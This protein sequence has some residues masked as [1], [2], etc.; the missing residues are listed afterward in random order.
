M[1]SI[2]VPIEQF[3]K[4]FYDR[5]ICSKGFSDLD[6]DKLAEIAKKL[7]KK[8]ENLFNKT[9]N[10]YEIIPKLDMYR[11]V[12]HYLTN[13]IIHFEFKSFDE[14]IAFLI[15]AVDPN[16]DMFKEY[17]KLDLVSKGDI[18]NARDAKE[19]ISLQQKRNQTLLEYEN[20]VREKLG[21]FDVKLLKYEELFFKRFFCDK[22]LITEVKNNNQDYLMLKARLL[23]NFDTVSDERFEELI[24]VA[25][26]WLSLVSDKKNAKA[27]GY[28]VINQKKLLGLKSVAEQLTLYILLVDSELDMLRIF[29]EES[30]M[31]IIE[32]RIIEQF[33][34]FDKELLILEKKYHERFC[35]DKELSIWSKTKKD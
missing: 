3:K 8:Q 16:L 7:Y 14:K 35:R 2:Y 34:F 19:K 6:D 11:N 10:G 22:E 1:A 24:D 13:P 28:S 18:E 4:K 29:E 9:T 27:A 20:T 12:L 26:S 21:F 23:K 5:E 17:L 15:M 32:E 25:Q 33:G 30:R 31:P